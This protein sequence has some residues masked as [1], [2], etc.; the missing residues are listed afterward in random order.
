[1]Y[2]KLVHINIVTS[3]V[4]KFYICIIIF[5]C[6]NNISPK[7]VTVLC[8]TSINTYMRNFS[9]QLNL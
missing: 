7:I 8:D 9:S 5:I 3:S 6:Y 2:M 1:M 4:Q